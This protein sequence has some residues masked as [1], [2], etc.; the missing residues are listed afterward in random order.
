MVECMTLECK[1]GSADKNL[2]GKSFGR[3]TVLDR[4]EENG[5]ARK[6]LCRC[7]CGTERFVSER[8]LIYGSS[9]SC[10]CLTRERA[11]EKNR[12]D[13][14]GMKFGELTV[15]CKSDKKNKGGNIYWL[16]R[17]SCGNEVEVSGTLLHCGKK[18]SCGCKTEFHN[19][20]SNIA[21]QRFHRL[22]A[23]Y[24]T[25]QRS[26]RGSVIWHCRCD[27]GNEVDVSYNTLVYGT[28]RSCGCRKKEHGQELSNLLVFQDGTSVDRLRSKKIPKNN[29]IG[30]K[31]VYS[32]RD[33]YIAKIVFQKKAYC[34]GTYDNIEDAASARKCAEE[35]ICDRAA[36]FYDKWKEKADKDQEWA[37]ENPIRFHVVKEEKRLRLEMLPELESSENMKEIK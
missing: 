33:K 19:A 37:K 26:S 10:G 2:A 36:D 4:F 24:P 25:K 1:N 28:I 21:G 31:G 14:C 34:L 16:C 30:V 11:S 9:R 6:W 23:L 13:L 3:W 17:C 5:T 7:E 12:H 35:A 20:K 29:T 8:N 22:V 32:L 18:T 15:L 27:C